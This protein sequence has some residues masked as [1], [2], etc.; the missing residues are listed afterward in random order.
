MGYRRRLLWSCLLLTLAGLGTLLL[1]NPP[2][3]PPSERAEPLD[4]LPAVRPDL[5]EVTV[6]PNI[7]PLNFQIE[8]KGDRFFVRI[9][10][11]HGRPIGVV[12]RS[13][14]IFI[15]RTPWRRLLES[16]RGE[17]LR[18][19]TFAR[20]PGGRWTR[21]QPLLLR[22]APEDIDSYVIYRTMHPVR[23]SW[24]MRLNCRSLESF[25]AATVL[26]YDSGFEA[27]CVNCHTPLRGGPD[28]L[29]IGLRSKRYG[30]A[31]LLIEN[32]VPKKIGRQFGYTSWHPDGKLAVFSVNDLPIF[33]HTARREIHDTADRDS[34]IACFRPD[35]REIRPH[36]LLSEK[37]VLENW[38]AWSADGRHLYFCSAPKL[39]ETSRGTPPPRYQ[40]VRYDLKRIPYDPEEDRWGSP[41][42]ILSAAETG[43]S[44][45]MP[46]LSPDGR[47]LSFCMFDHGFFPNWRD[48]SDLY[49]LD[50]K[51]PR[52]EGHFPFRRLEINS[53]R[54]ESWHSWSSNSRWLVFS[55]KRDHGI[56]TRLYLSYMDSEGRPHKPFLLPQKDPEFYDSCLYAFNTPEFLTGPLTCR[57]RDVDTILRQP[58]RIPVDAVTLPTPGPARPGPDASTWE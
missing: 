48:E 28:R 16:N 51:A 19:D 7:A 24:T 54:S 1:T 21:F 4:R 32:G 39:W 49:V 31:T 23:S 25:D 45:A 40:E 33:F 58:D 29:L 27:V 57:Q 44:I 35:R 38:P 22:I 52:K 6:P 20:E 55:S 8:E 36:P 26:R 42:T 3:E 14:K 10:S 12:S 5:H 34:Y 30:I 9:H 18:M 50:L 17:E 13:G 53:P 15:P 41:E 43:R 46:R 11:R 47:W 2:E 37:Q 56:F